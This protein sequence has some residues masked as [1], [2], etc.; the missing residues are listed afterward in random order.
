MEAVNL[1]QMLLELVLAGEGSLADGFAEA[2]LVFVLL[3]KMLVKDQRISFWRK[4]RIESGHARGHSIIGVNILFESD[5][6]E[7]THC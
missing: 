3:L 6:A 2:R 7:I 1:Q 5:A 4:K